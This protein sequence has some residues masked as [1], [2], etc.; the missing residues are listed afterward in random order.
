MFSIVVIFKTSTL[1][2]KIGLS[3]IVPNSLCSP[4]KNDAWGPGYWT[5]VI[6][7]REATMTVIHLIHEFSSARQP[8]QT[9]KSLLIKLECVSC[10]NYFITFDVWS[11]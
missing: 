1:T 6:H 2:H 4:K 5:V 10:T 7:S 11:N 8:L 3:K 9:N